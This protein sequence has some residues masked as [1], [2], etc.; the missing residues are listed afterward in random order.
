MAFAFFETLVATSAKGYFA[1]GLDANHFL[2]Q[3]CVAFTI[4]FGGVAL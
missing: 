2:T 3:F 4:Y 1:V